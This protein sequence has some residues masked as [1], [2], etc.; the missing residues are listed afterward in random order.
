MRKKPWLNRY[1]DFSQV[2]FGIGDAVWCLVWL[3]D[4]EIHKLFGRFLGLS[5]D[6]VLLPMRL[7]GPRLSKWLAKMDFT[8]GA[9]AFLKDYAKWIP[10]ESYIY[11]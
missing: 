6:M 4:L 5:L 10:Y 3:A 7:S 1:L 8:D 11:I 2:G 9:G